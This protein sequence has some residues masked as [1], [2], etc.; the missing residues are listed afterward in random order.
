M[1]A[2]RTEPPP[3]SDGADAAAT[4]D[5]TRTIADALTVLALDACLRHAD[6]TRSVRAA[7]LLEYRDA[8][9]DRLA[10][11]KGPTP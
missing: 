2:P 7:R 3:P 10:P 8:A 11:E 4:L 5:F 1:I 6:P 9:A